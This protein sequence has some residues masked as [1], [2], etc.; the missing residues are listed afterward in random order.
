M[1]ETTFGKERPTAAIFG[2]AGTSAKP[3]GPTVSAREMHA[4]HGEA[5]DTVSPHMSA[6]APVSAARTDA[7]TPVSPSA[8]SLISGAASDYFFSDAETL[9]QSP[10]ASFSV[11]PRPPKMDQ[12][13]AHVTHGRLARARLAA[14]S[15]TP[16]LS[17]SMDGGDAYDMRGSR[18]Q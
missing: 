9:H 7:A 3:S 13:R 16:S 11:N 6:T 17:D 15:R 4:M 5:T 10:T 14:S 1:A 12:S 18:G 2:L 8:A